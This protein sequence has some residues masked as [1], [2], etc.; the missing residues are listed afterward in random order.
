MLMSV[1]GQNDLFGAAGMFCSEESYV[2]D[3]TAKAATDVLMIP[4]GSLKDMMRR[5]FRITENYLKYLTSRIRFL[6]QRIDGFVMPTTEA[7]LLLYIETNAVDGAFSPKFPLTALADALCI[8]RA[9]LYRA[10][11]TLTARGMIERK[12]RTIIVK[13]ANK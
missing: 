3:I 11:D 9:T 7:R 4:E 5:D 2:V 8:S 6:N 13:E 10:L 1:L 12:G